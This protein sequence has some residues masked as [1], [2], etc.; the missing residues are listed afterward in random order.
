[1]S[2]KLINQE[3]KCY[4]KILKVYNDSKNNDYNREYNKNQSI[5]KLFKASDCKNKEQFIRNALIMV[6]SL[7]DEKPAD[8]YA[9]SGK[10]LEDCNNNQREA[11][12][13]MLK[14]EL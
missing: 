14:A 6:L 9:N 3:S 7:Y 8:L 11:A 5:I 13:A 12:L 10:R 1:M 4:S 2:N